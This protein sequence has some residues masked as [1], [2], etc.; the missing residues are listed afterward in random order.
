M[1]VRFA[2]SKPARWIGTRPRQA[3]TRCF[4]VTVPCNGPPREP[5]CSLERSEYLSTDPEAHLESPRQ[6][7]L[8]Q[9]P[10][11]GCSTSF[12]QRQP[13]AGNA[14]TEGTS[15]GSWTMADGHLGNRLAGDQATGE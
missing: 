12:F 4:D 10:G 1:A 9:K 3:A 7:A 15:V 13:N 5:T 11:T 14:D 2:S 6:E 8:P